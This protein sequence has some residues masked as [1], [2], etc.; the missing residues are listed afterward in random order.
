MSEY[1]S[2][3]NAVEEL[4]KKVPDELGQLLMRER[5]KFEHTDSESWPDVP[6]HY[7]Q[8]LVR[9]YGVWLRSLSK[10]DQEKE[11]AESGGPNGGANVRKLLAEDQLSYHQI[12]PITCRWI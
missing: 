8:G 2:P 3:R 7:G 1:I 5:D 9:E 10:Q 12:A 4:I 6:Y 11:I